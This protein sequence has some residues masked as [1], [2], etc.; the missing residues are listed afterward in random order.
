MWAFWRLNESGGPSRYGHLNGLRT[1][2]SPRRLEL[3]PYAVGRS[4]NIEPADPDDPFQDPNEIDS[5]F[6]LDLK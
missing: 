6:G 4:R 3:L 1:P 2:P 5:R